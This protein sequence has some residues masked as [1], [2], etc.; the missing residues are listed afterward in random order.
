MSD[1]DS[2]PS[3]ASAP[4]PTPGPVAFVM[5]SGANLGAVQVGML[6]ALTEC[7]ICPD[8]VVGSSVGAINGAG[9]SDDPTDSGIARLENIWCTI[10]SRDLLPRRR[11]SSAWA[12]ARRGAAIH[13]TYG[14][15]QVMSRVF[16]AAT[17]EEL[18]T[19]FHCV[20]TDVLHAR[21]AWFTSGPL[22]D[23]VLA[24]AALPAVYPPVEID[25]QWYMDGG[26]VV[27]VPIRRAVELGARTLYVLGLGRLS[28]EWAEP[29]RPFDAAVEAYWVARRHRFQRDLD[30]MPDDV[31][32][33]MLP[34]EQP[35]KLRFDD[36]AYSAELIDM[37]YASTIA[38]LAQLS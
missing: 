36:C 7:D 10:D 18:K 38:Y 8:V 1:T 14:L 29:R 30:A 31:T 35:A 19:P 2:D 37:G 21:E 33:H 23:V 9:F 25:G 15:R 12:L 22:T 11:V 20:A 28:R 5:S 4:V 6:R 26:V 24:S 3:S 13:P 16:R 17:F 34:H 27:D 32:I